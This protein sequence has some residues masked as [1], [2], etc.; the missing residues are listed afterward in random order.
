[1]SSAELHEV[2]PFD[3]RGRS[4]LITGGTAG[5]GL[6]TAS[7]F[8]AAGADVVISGRDRDRGAAA[9]ADLAAGP[10]GA[11]YLPADVSSTDDIERLVEHT[12]QQHGKLDVLVNNAAY[13]FNSPLVDT[14]LEDYQRVMDT[15]LRSYYYASVLAVRHMA[16]RRSGAIVNINSVTSEHP[17][18]GTGLYA[19]AKGGVKLLTRA[20]A[21]EHG[22][23]GI[24]VN[25]INP[26]TIHTAIFDAPQSAALKEG[27]IASTPL[28]RLGRPE[29]IAAAVLFL[30]SDAS[31]F[32][33]G[34]SWLIDGGLTI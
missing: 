26:G 3:F 11:T 6:A 28:G 15:N 21:I 33:T 19:M 10:G 1:M 8:V 14:T 9:V 25:E 23:D 18:P 30:A 2:G 4:V 31:S 12:L 34:S 29:E 13:E 5:I 16:P 20:M 7:A 22:K 32:T 27:A 24:R 17:V